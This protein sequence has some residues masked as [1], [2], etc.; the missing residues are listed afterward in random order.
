METRR[1]MYLSLEDAQNLF[2][3]KGIT[4]SL[5]EMHSMAQD[6]LSGAVE[7]LEGMKEG[8]IAKYDGIQEGATVHDI[9]DFLKK[10]FARTPDELVAC[11]EAEIA[12]ATE[13][14]YGPNGIVTSL[15]EL[16][17]PNVAGVVQTPRYLEA[18]VPAAAIAVPA[19]LSDSVATSTYYLSTKQDS[20]GQIFN[21]V[22]SGVIAAHEVIPGH[23]YQGAVSSVYP[24]IVLG[25]SSCNDT[26][27]GWTTY[28]VEEKMVE[29]G[30]SPSA[31][32]S[33][34]L[35]EQFIAQ[36]DL[37]RMGGRVLF[38]LA[39]LTG[40]RKYLVN[41][42]AEVPETD[43]IINA[44]AEM[45]RDITH[46]SVGRVKAEIGVFTIDG[47]YGTLYCIGNHEL[48][49]MDEAAQAK[50]GDDY[51]QKEFFAAVIGK[52]NRPLSMIERILKHDEMI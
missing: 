50:L 35:E 45:Y 44:S 18:L 29:N 10:E 34:Q 30:F 32:P 3:Y 17:I 11:A 20:A 41:P 5:D 36:Y 2:K 25:W 14:A 48:R 47:T 28:A 24:S 4:L 1:E 39:C 19:T 40:D 31:D 22:V 51:N 43:D 27:E 52:G 46:F 7:R 21:S 42:I 16:G 13:F 37:L 23:H 15:E 26:L 8:L 6:Q 9:A 38:T 49:R 12:R 33:L